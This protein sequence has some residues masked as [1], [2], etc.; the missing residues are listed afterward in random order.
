MVVCGTRSVIDAVF[1]PTASGSPRR[2]HDQR[3]TQEIYAILVVYQALRTAIVDAALTT[4]GTDPGRASF[5]V[6]LDTT[7]GQLTLAAG[8]LDN[9]DDLTG[10]IGE[11]I[12]AAP[13][14]GAYA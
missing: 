5:T 3:V 2:S 12:L 13:R 11:V 4:P 9:P 8:V 7:R 1:G 10:K 6:A 14:T